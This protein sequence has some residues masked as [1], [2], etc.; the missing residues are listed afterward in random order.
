MTISRHVDIHGTCYGIT[1]PDAT[2]HAMVDRVRSRAAAEGVSI[3]HGKCPCSGRSYHHNGVTYTKCGEDG[4]EMAFWDESDV[5]GG[6]TFHCVSPNGK[7]CVQ[8]RGALMANAKV[9]AAIRSKLAERGMTME[10]GSCSSD[11]F[12]TQYAGWSKDIHGIHI[13]VWT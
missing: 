1:G 4:A 3:E 7:A 8:F 6:D 5:L 11:G 2:I 10:S 13:T 9:D 12:G